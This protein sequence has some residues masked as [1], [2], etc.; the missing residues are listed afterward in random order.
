MFIS[1]DSNE[2]KQVEIYN[3]LGKVVLN[4]KIINA[5]INISTIAAGVYVVKI[6]E[7]G[8]TATRKLV[9]E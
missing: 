9:I 7:A 8:K 4:T 6:T 1:S 2:I 5:S 3:V